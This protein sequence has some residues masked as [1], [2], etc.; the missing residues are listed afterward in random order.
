MSNEYVLDIIG[1]LHQTESKK[2]INVDIKQLEKVINM[3][4]LTG[5]FAKG[6]TKKEL[7]A[8]IKSLQSQLAHIKLAAEV[9]SR[10]LKSEVDKALSGMSFKDIDAF[11]IDENKARLKIRKVIADAKAYAEKT[12]ITVNIESKKTK[13]GNDLTTYL[14]RN[15]KINESSVLLEEAEKV[16]ELIN[17]INDRKTLREAT[18]AFQLYKSEVSATGFNTK[19]TTDK[20]KDMLG[21]VSKISSAFGIASMAVNNFVKSLRTLKSND[22]ILVEISKTSEM[23]KQQLKELGDEAFRTASK[24]GQLSSGYLLGVQEMA[25]SGYE[26]TSKELGELSLLAQSAGD[27]TA[28]NANNYLLATDAAYKYCGSVEK[29]NA[30][31]DG[32]NYISNKNSASLTDIADATRVSA[33]FAANA[34][35]AIDELTAAEATMIATTKRSGSEIGRAFRSIVLNLQQVS[36]EFDGEVIDEEQ[37]KKVEARCHSLGVELEYMQNGIATLRNPMEILKDL[38][39]VY[40]SLPDNSAE[41]QGLI[42]DLGGK[43]HANALSSLLARWDLYEKMLSEFS[44]GTGSALE[45][46]EKTANSWE[47]RLNSLQNSWDSFI[48]SLTN[49]TAITSGISFFD[50][51]I[52]GAESLT[53]TIGEIPVVLTAVNSAMVAMNKDYGITQV[54]DKDKGKV[55]IQGNIFG[56]DFTTIKSQKKH[57]EDA[58]IAI[59]DWNCELAAGKTDLELFENALIKNNAQ[60]R[61]Y[62]S[63]CSKEAPA[64]LSGYKAHLNAAG[65]STDALRLKTVLLNSAISMGIGIAIQA[66]VQGITYLIQKEENL[67][68]A[69]EE[70][71]NAYKESASS[72][73]DYTSRYQ[74]LRKALLAA[75][76]NEE[77]TYSV[78]KQLLELQTELNDKFADEY[79]AINLVTDAYKDQ[80][81]AIKVLNKETAQAFLNEN[82]KGVDKAEKAMTKGRHYNL[83]LTG[84]SAYTDEGAVLKEVAEKYKGQGVSLMDELGDGSYSQFSIHI[85]ADAQSAYD[86]INA[87]ENDLRGRAKELGDEHMFDDVL[88]VSSAS[89]N[90]AKE[91]IDKYGDIFRQALTAEIASD[92]GLSSTYNEVLK[93]VDAYNEAVLRSENIYDD[94][95]VAKAKEGL[96]AVKDSIQGNETEWGRYAALVDEVF[97]QADTRL[98]EFN[99]ALKTDSGIRGLAE[100]LKGLNDLDLR[101]FN[102]TGENGSF[103]RLKESAEEYNVSVDEL[104]DS[105]VRLGYVQGEMQRG[106]LSD[107]SFISLSITETISQLNTQLKPTFD[108]LKSAYQDIFTDD[109]FTLENVDLSMLDSIKSKLDE[110]NELEGA[111]IS[112]DYSS[113]DNLVRVLT[114]TSSTADDVQAAFNSLATDIVGALN[115]AISECSGENYKLVQSLLESVGIMNSEEVM[116]SSL[117]YT[118]E[119]YIAAKEEAA[120]AGFDLANATES[121]IDAFVRE[122]LESGNCGQALA[123]LQLK[124]LL[125]NSTSINTASDIQQIMNLASA[126]GMGAEVLTQLANA[127]SILGTV[128]AGGSVSLNSYQ[129]ALDDVQSAKQSMLDWKPVEVDFGNVGGGKKSAGSAGKEAA[130][131]YLEAFEKELADLDDLKSRGKITEKQ[132][133]DALRKLY[134][135]YFRDKEKYLK[136]YAKYEHQYLDGMKSLYESAFS[137]ITK[138]I[139]KRI[140]ATNAEKDATVSAL[141]AE[142]DARLEAIEAQKEQLENE[143]EGIEKEIEAKEKEIKAMQDANEERKRS[144]DLQKAEYDLQR[145]QNQKTSLVYKDGQV[146]YE[147]DTSGIRDAKQEVEDAKLEIDISKIEKEIGLLEEQKDLLQ[148]QIDLLDKEADRVNDYYDKL[149]AGTEK[150]YD[151]MVKG[152][153]QYRSQFEELLELS[154]NARLE[155]TLSELGI[156]MD[157]LLNGSQEEFEKMKGAY[158]G[159]LADMNR[160]NEEMIGQLSRLAGVNAESV[161]YLESTKGAFE[162]LG[163]VT[164]EGLG[165]S[166]DGVA[167]SASGLATSAGEASEAVGGIQKSVDGTSQSIAPLNVELEKLNSLIMVLTSL[168]NS[169]EFP[170]I[171]D[172]G[173]A[174]KL[175]DIAQA[176]GEIASKCNEFKTIDFSSIIGTGSVTTAGNGDPL[177]GGSVSDTQ[178]QAG[179]GFMGLAS[180][181]LSAVSSI[182]EQMGILEDAL[183]RGNDAF[184]EQIRVI[185]EEYIPAWEGLQKRLAEIIGVGGG[186][187]KNGKKSKGGDNGK[188]SSGGS[189]GSGG[190]IIGTIE[191][192]GIEVGERLQDPWLKSFNDF[193]TD[194]DNSIQ[195]ICDK[196]IGLVTEMADIIQEKCAAAAAALDALASKAASAL[197]SV[198]GG[199][200]HAEGTVGNAFAEGTGGYKGLPHDEKNALRSEYGQPELTVYPDGKTEL[201]TEP[202]MSDLPK[203]TVIFNEEQTRQIMNNEGEVVETYKSGTVRMSDG[204]VITP[205]GKVHYPL[206][207]SDPTY[208]MMKKF[209]EYFAVNKDAFIKPANAMLKVAE[210]AD[211]VFETINNNNTMNRN[212]NVDVGGVHVHGVQNPEEFSDV[213]NLRIHNKILQEMHKY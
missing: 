151:A 131:A 119:E 35:V 57:F 182:S 51:L 65:I 210:S 141:E 106:D 155:A 91:T 187:D 118:Y 89:L 128:E 28:D 168:L 104:V 160:G 18:D 207:P 69:T 40:N 117:G 174:Q 163:T 206:T 31:L 83:S 6:D 111:N 211:R 148:E 142:R 10:K 44:Q 167:D 129:K 68:Q 77:E 193:A 112:I 15:T 58:S 166:V 185:T 198:G 103:N 21:H 176:F 38:A 175:R 125:V 180:A 23:T 116:A 9:D 202:V 159:I 84:I 134:L 133:L 143:I 105:L 53:D 188:D 75:K 157:A 26:D 82:K 32:A 153:E 147:A 165:S 76:G 162:N 170:E 150:Q 25:R 181:M 4:R 137:Y 88:D 199:S 108:A 81:E 63:A 169:I 123:L 70:A 144:L 55:D 205:E 71:A 115:P 60:L 54:W 79:G 212:I 101:A 37:L 12:P 192:G 127:K 195:T 43:Y 100:N 152:M 96:D 121:E 33:S 46:A 99:E 201:T 2:Q 172:E 94:G 197:S 8:Y 45:E 122:A 161:S 136:E 126:A 177:S 29:L 124:K 149:I 158:I 24:Y 19:S 14:N 90:K 184:T 98:L 145:M 64:S 66:A 183:Q 41:K 190:S 113:F 208:Q 56:I 209:E 50:R 139:D 120:D 22:T 171:G 80:T 30:A 72:I 196:I 7:N 95:S 36:G 87:F 173:Y 109:G 13:L 130:D 20:I 114:D 74:E 154:E 61:N 48:N 42:S 186:D 164:L 5:T 92:D 52:Q 146:S 191:S 194:G 132:Y 17:V 204:T 47:G 1:A 213:V 85:N 178:G 97:S 34:G 86:T 59:S 102:E 110:L 62:L 39:D 27:M 189:G 78:K 179:T 11:N 135:K 156:N 67:R 203:G 73:G 49:K 200:G 107:K 140:D 138:Q 3:L 93:A 16:R